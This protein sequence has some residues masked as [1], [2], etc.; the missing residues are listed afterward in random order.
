MDDEDSAHRV[1]VAERA[2]RAGGDVALSRFRRG[3]D[4]ETKGEKTDVV[5][6]ADRRAQQRV[7][8]VLTES[9][10][11]DAIVGEEEGA[12][13][14]VPEGGAA[15]IVDP[16]DG[17]NNF[18]R[19]IPVWATSVAAVIDGEPVAAANVMPALGDRYV[20]ARTVRRNGVETS[21]SDRTDP[22]RCT[23]VPTMWWDRDHRAEYTAAAGAIVERFG[24]MRRFGCAQAAL[25]HVADGGIDGLFYEGYANPWDTVAGVHL[26][27]RAG[28]RVTDVHGERWRHDS[29]GIVASNG[30]VHDEV[31]EAARAPLSV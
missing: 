4:V 5:T 14:E 21:V 23:V 8:E 13:K 22:E 29:E 19:E 30:A 3:I 26:V 6:E 28:G 10:P 2:A 15:W 17:T 12:L 16:I 24:D 25:S 31:L 9:F 27:R 7:I 20:G 18:V 1:A 11:D